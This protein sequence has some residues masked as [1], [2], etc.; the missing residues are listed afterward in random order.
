MYANQLNSSSIGQIGQPI[1]T[2]VLPP[3]QRHRQHMG[4]GWTGRFVCPL[5]EDRYRG[6]LMNYSIP[7]TPSII[8]MRVYKLTCRSG[9]LHV[10][11]PT[12]SE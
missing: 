7:S 11:S 1:S 3:G 2:Q 8:R 9:N 6:I 10:S 4:M 12:R 5:H